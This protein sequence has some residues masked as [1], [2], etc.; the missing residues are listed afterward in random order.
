MARKCIVSAVQ[1]DC[2]PGDRD[3]NLRH[4]AELVAEAADEGA[5]IV[6][7]PELFSTGYRVEARD[8][9]LAESLS[10]HTIRWMQDAAQ[11]HGVYLAAAILERGEDGL[12]YDTAVLVG[13]EGCVGRHR[14][15]HLWDA[16]SGRFAKG[17]EIGVYR[18]PFATVGLLIC[19]EI[20]FPEMARIQALKGADVLLYPSAFGRARDYV[21]DIASKSR[22]LENGVF[23]VACNRCGQEQDTSFGGLSR[24]VAPDASLLAAAGVDGEAVVSAEIDLDAV[25][26]MRKTL[27]YLRDLNPRLRNEMF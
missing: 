4:A 9:D 17:T 19:Y 13:A 25:A 15:M 10:G 26:A 27:P 11:R 14:K 1:M 23:V 20:G 2:I 8:V 6:V 18:L 16:E 5:Q 12:V 7:L 24:V 22:A 3:A 21:W